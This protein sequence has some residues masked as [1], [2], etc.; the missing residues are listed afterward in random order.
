MLHPVPGTVQYSTGTLWYDIVCRL[1][2]TVQVL[3]RNLFQSCPHNHSSQQ[4]DYQ[5]GES[6]RTSLADAAFAIDLFAFI[7]DC[8]Y[9]EERIDGGGIG[10]KG[11]SGRGIPYLLLSL[12]LHF[13]QNQ[14][15]DSPRLFIIFNHLD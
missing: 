5:V 6:L 1:S 2:I 14:L 3:S 13:F 10:K 7:P 11:R 8:T 9:Y 12:K 15:R 4:D